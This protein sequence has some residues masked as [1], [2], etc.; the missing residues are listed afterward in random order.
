MEIEV[1]LDIELKEVSYFKIGGKVKNLYYPKSIDEFTYLLK[2]LKNPLVFGGFSNVLFSSSGVKEDIIC[3][4]KMDTYKINEVQVS[5]LAGVR[6]A[7]LSRACMENSLTGFEFMSGFP[8]SIGGNIYMNA[9]AHKQCISDNLISVKIYDT[10]QKEILELKK[11][12]LNF[13]YRTSILQTKPYILLEA[14]FELKKGDKNSIQ[15]TI[16]NNREFRKAHQPQALPNVGSIFRNPDGDSAGRMLDEIGAKT[17]SVGGAKVFERHANFIINDNNA[18]STDVLE[19]MLMMY[20]KVKER[21]DINLKPEVK[22][23]GEK[24]DREKEICTILFQ[25]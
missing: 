19:L 15:Q 7:V 21:F 14:T 12:D 16:L 8:G 11:E 2:S 24:T 13:S 25:K 6:G 23:F 4:Q 17:F 22:Y 5:A 18:T 3:T 20:N 10:V 1:K 9:S